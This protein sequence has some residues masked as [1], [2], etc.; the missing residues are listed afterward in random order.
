[1]GKNWVNKGFSKWNELSQGVPQVLVLGLLLFNIDLNDL[2]F[3][4]D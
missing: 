4:V 1:M 3:L 2:F